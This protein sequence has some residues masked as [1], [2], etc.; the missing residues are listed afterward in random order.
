VVVIA[1]VD[2]D[3]SILDAMTLLVE[4]QGWD[5]AVYVSGEA[6]LDDY[7]RNGKIDCLIL[8]PHLGGISGADVAQALS[9]SSIPI[10][11]LTARP[12]SPVTQ[13]I[14][15]LGVET[16]LTKPVQPKHLVEIIKQLISDHS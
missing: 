15:E 14:I 7:R 6:F 11:G 4:G 9:G 10:I 2:D 1:I 5:A 12:E 13:S 3:E 8:D 16:M